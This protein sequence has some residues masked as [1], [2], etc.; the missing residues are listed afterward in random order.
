MRI[1]PLF[2]ALAALAVIGSATA[3]RVQAAESFSDAQKAELGEIIRD[4]LV[5][6]PEVLQE[7]F[8][9]LDRKQ[10][11][12]ESDQQK[13]VL[14]AVGPKLNSAEDG[15]V[16]GN[17]KGDVTIVEFFDYNCGY[18]KKAMTDIMAMMKAD[19]KLR[20]VLRDFPVLGPDSLDASLV[21]LAARNQFSG[22]KY[23]EYHQALLTS[24]GRIGKERALEVAKDLG[25]DMDKLK[26]D[27]D[28]GEPRK[29]IDSTMRIA[30][31]LKIGGTPSFVV[32]DS[33][34][35]G[36]VGKD[37][38]AGAVANLRSCGKSVC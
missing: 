9:E 29:L 10:K 38:L 36:A 1:R 7:A 4:Y 33:L 26:K 12:A 5:K 8:E 35:I 30:D 24:K 20:V 34:I 14:A 17:P 23:M 18:C 15:I 6:N 3:M 25:A 13:K 31:Q 2:F 16:V 19:P 32:G 37:P 28:S 21:A 22:D 11:A 27:L